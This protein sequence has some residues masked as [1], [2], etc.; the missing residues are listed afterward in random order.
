MTVQSE[1]PLVTFAL[2][3]YNQEKYIAEAV[4]AALAQ[5]YPNLEIIISDDCSSDGTWRTIEAV[6][7]AYSGPHKVKLNRNPANLGI[8]AHVSLVGRMALGELVVMAAGDDAS[9]P[10]RVSALCEIWQAAG[11]GAAVIYSDFVPIDQQSREIREWDE[12]V[13][14]GPQD[15]HDMA[16][17]AIRIL[18]ATTAYTSSV[19]REF[20]D[21]AEY[22]AHED[23]VLPFRALLLNGKVIYLASRLV[24]YRVEGGVSRGFPRSRRDYL[25]KV[26]T[27][28]ARG[29]KD[30]SQRLTDL[31]RTPVHWGSV[32]TECIRTVAT[33]YALWEMANVKGLAIEH[34]VLRGM[35]NGADRMQ[36]LRLY[37]KLRLQSLFGGGADAS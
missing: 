15:M 17:G 8:G 7:A 18:G 3:A 4:Q 9:C 36:V 12:R 1:Y 29:M 35:L 20:D 11:G 30:A 16:R 34:S 14:D 28:E 2:F 32:G 27:I 33:H 21:I 10:N 31:M 13:F 37:V 23:R 24:R 25:R 19:F 5:D 22:V 6:M 26:A